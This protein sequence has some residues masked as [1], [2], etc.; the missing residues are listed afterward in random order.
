M[1]WRCEDSS[2][3]SK[4]GSR[5]SIHEHASAIYKPSSTQSRTRILIQPM[6]LIRTGMY[7]YGI[8]PFPYD[9][10]PTWPVVAGHGPA[11]I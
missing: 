1:T 10:L 5:C 8:F 11:S 3:D 6:L 9:V 7:H 4:R 2:G